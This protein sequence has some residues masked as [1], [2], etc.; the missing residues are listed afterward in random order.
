MG[1]NRIVKEANDVADKYNLK[2]LEIDRTDNI[3]S[4]KLS[5][6]NDLFI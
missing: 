2:L 3:I 4:L 5:I 6:D 1:I